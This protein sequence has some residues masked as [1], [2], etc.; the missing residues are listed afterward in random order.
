MWDKLKEEHLQYGKDLA[1]EILDNE[2][3]SNGLSELLRDEFPIK[4]CIMGEEVMLI[5]DTRLNK[6]AAMEIFGT[7]DYEKIREN[8]EI[9][10]DGENVS[11]VYKAKGTGEYIS[12]AKLQIRQKGVGYKYP[13]SFNMGIH[14]EFNRYLSEYRDNTENK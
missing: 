6:K 5:G 3:L 9:Q 13:P 7:D 12:I 2:K 11:I 1:Q 4:S 8:F 10:Q 14:K